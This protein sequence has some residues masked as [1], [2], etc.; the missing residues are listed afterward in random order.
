[1][2][3]AIHPTG[4]QRHF[5]NRSFTMN[6]TLRLTLAAALFTVV[7]GAFAHDPAEHAKEA[8]EAKAKAHCDAMNKMDMSKMDPNDA[9]MKAM[10]AKCSA[11]AKK[12]AAKADAA[13]PAHDMKGMDMKGM[14]MKGMEMP[15]DAAKKP[16]APKEH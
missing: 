12:P 5:L 10:M 15:A 9:V 6:S 16:D 14:D 2:T 13:K 1:M 8:E 11:A 4:A 3:N 7:Q